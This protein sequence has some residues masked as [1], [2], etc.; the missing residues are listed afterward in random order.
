MV[1]C[2]SCN[3]LRPVSKRAIRAKRVCID[4]RK[5]RVVYRE[6]FYDFWTERFTLEEIKDL[7][8]AIWG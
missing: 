2:P 3:G 4:C 6:D 8:R 1:R 7:G 5:G